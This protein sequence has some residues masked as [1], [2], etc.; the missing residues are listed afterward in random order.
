M[1]KNRRVAFF[2]FQLF[3]F[4]G[5][6]EAAKA[7][8]GDTL[9]SVRVLTDKSTNFSDELIVNTM[10]RAFTSCVYAPS[11]PQYCSAIRVRLPKYIRK[12]ACITQLG[13]DPLSVIAMIFESRT[14]SRPRE[15]P[16]TAVTFLARALT[17]LQAQTLSRIS[18]AFSQE[19]SSMALGL[20]AKAECSQTEL[21]KG[22]AKLSWKVAATPGIAQ[23]V[24]VSIYRD[25]FATG[26]FET[27]GSLSP[28][29]SSL[30]W[31]RLEPGIIHYYRVLT[32]HTH[33]WVGSEIASF[34]GPTCVADFQ[35]KPHQ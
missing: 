2:L 24:D 6:P 22:I 28:S 21:R 1:Y 11:S 10:H 32:L 3:V 31:Q 12:D 23:R 18:S 15:A 35:L 19:S 30:E 9:T 20:E 17:P 27:A 14:G 8:A 5:F 26:N 33:G 25:G 13:S 16:Q 4:T 29:Q 7:A 34:E